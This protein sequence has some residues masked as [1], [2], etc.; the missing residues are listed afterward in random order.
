M[1]FRIQLAVGRKR[2]RFIN[3]SFS[4]FFFFGFGGTKTKKTR[5]TKD[6]TLLFSKNVMVQIDCLFYCSLAGP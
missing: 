2:H 3:P 5:G 6:D 1:S 4:L